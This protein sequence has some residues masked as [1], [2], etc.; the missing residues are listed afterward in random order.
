MRSLEIRHFKCRLWTSKPRR[1]SRGGDVE[2]TAKA[3]LTRQDKDKDKDKDKGDEKGTCKGKGKV[4][5]RRGNED[6]D[7]TRR[8]DKHH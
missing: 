3:P 2:I 8:D 7:K 5:T 1:L 6:N 4:K